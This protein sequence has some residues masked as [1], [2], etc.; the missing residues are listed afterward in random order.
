M[1]QKETF[2]LYLTPWTCVFLCLSTL[3]AL[4][5]RLQVAELSDA[6]KVVEL[7]P[8]LHNALLQNY[9]AEWAV[10]FGSV[11]DAFVF[12]SSL[13]AAGRAA[14][15]TDPRL[16]GRPMYPDA[17][18]AARTVAAPFAAGR[19]Y[20]VLRNVPE[21]VERFRALR[22][23]LT[24]ACK[25]RVVFGTLDEPPPGR[26][27]GQGVVAL[28]MQSEAD[29]LQMVAVMDGQ[30]LVPKRAEA[31]DLRRLRPLKACHLLF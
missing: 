12:L 3:C 25:F 16:F 19:S 14:K 24:Q 27:P 11:G 1:L 8:I 9:R 6:S 17:A 26:E 18:Q 30:R 10:T 23:R 31:V 22:A 5:T 13:N 4:L 29:C 7:V 20:L 28:E 2:G 15:E 21:D